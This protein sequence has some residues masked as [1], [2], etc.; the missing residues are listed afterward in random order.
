MISRFWD[1]VTYFVQYICIELA[2]IYTELLPAHRG[3][4]SIVAR[5]DYHWMHH[6]CIRTFQKYKMFFL[7]A[8]RCSRWRLD[9]MMIKL[10]QLV[11]SFNNGND[12]C[13][14]FSHM[15]VT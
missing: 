10:G 8:F 14:F 7:A 9:G 13:R 5:G 12:F 1:S 4:K 2:V 15:T 3:G 6:K 11:S